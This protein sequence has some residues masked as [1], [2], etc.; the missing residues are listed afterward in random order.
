[1]LNDVQLRIDAQL[2]KQRAATGRVRA[3][4]LKARQPGVST[5]VAG[6]FYRRVTSDGGVR[7]FILTH[8]EQ[9]TDNLF[10]IVKRFH[11]HYP[12]RE[13]QDTKHA[14]ARELAFAALDSG[15]QVGT[16]KASG[17]GRSDTIQL[18]HGSEVA[19]WA[20]A[21][22]HAAGAL[23]AVPNQDSTEIILES[24]ANGVSGLFY[25]M[26]VRASAG[27]SEYIPVF[28]PWQA[29]EEYRAQPRKDWAAPPEFAE[30]G[31]LHGLEPDQL[32]WA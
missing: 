16:A 13:K 21:E 32:Y 26:W 22:E 12:K 18:F 6:R 1:M 2:E 5:Y 27:D 9:A 10:A 24:T 28:M 3:L 31:A 30:Y 19:F 25:S 23:Q 29:H 8:R 20:N 17:V 14:N 4:I 15:Y 11:D 7:A